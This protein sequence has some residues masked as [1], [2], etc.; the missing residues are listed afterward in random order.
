MKSSSVVVPCRAGFACTVLLAMLPLSGCSRDIAVS[1]VLEETSGLRSGDRVYL[2][3]REVGSIDRIDADGQ[4]PGSIIEFNLYPEHAELVQE[5]AVAY[6]PLESPPR[7]VLV[8][9]TEAAAAVVP[10]GAPEGSVSIRAGGL[11]GE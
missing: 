8:N 7:L 9:P 6:I 3:A 1:T 5:N 2:D 4:A 10:G 11:A